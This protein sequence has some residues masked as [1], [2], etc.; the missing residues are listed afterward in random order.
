MKPEIIRHFICPRTAQPLRLDGARGDE[1]AMLE[2]RLVAENVSYDIHDG[3]PGFVS[4]DA[5]ES[6][7]VRSFD[8]KWDRH[9]YYR[10][11]TRDFYS[12]WYRN[13]YGFLDA[14]GIAD[15]LR[16]KTFILDAG[17]GMGRDALIFAEHCHA[18]I[19]AVDTS[20][21]ALQTAARDIKHPCITF[22]QADIAHLPFPDGFFDFINC[23]QVIHHTPAPK[24]T[25][26]HLAGKLKTGGQL[27]CYVYRKKGAIREF[28]DDYLRDRVKHLPVD[29]ALQVCESITR[30]GRSLASLGVS[31]EIE[32]DI[33]LLGIPKGRQDV[34]RLFHWHVMKCFWNDE[35]DFFT[36][37]I[38]NFDWY[39]PEHCFRFTPEEFRAW[40]AH[41]WDIEAWDV[42]EAGISCRARKR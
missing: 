34:Q 14:K 21:S 10:A 35:F 18:E 9:R 24:A 25:F 23:D 36:N 26:D 20:R 38:V 2:G 11:H 30:L 42:Q 15:F 5:L 40:F 8:Q 12:R 41:G 4:A 28:T 22:V 39:H 19:F 27:C 13:R 33:P 1:Q 7:T 16:D 32:E 17:T 37:N 3:I 6:Q 31:V 29:E